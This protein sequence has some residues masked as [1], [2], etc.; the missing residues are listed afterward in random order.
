MQTQ[1]AAALHFLLLQ[2]ADDSS[3]MWGILLTGALARGRQSFVNSAT[4]LSGRPGPVE[5]GTPRRGMAA[6]VFAITSFAFSL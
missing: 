2:V 5:A 4:G 3:T 6:P 1:A